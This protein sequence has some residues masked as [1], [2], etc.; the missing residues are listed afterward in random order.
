[1]ANNCQVVIVGDI[2]NLGSHKRN[3]QRKGN[4]MQF[5]KVFDFDI[6]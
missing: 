2:H 6:D 3:R 1:M 5:S 4:P